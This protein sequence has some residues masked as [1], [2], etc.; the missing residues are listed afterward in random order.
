LRAQ[1]PASSPPDDLIRRV[2]ARETENEAARNDYTYRQTVTVEDLDPH[3]AR[4]G[5]YREV[6]DIVFSPAMVRS[7]QVVE[8]PRNTLK[9]L[10][11]TEEDFRDIREIQPLLIT[12]ESLFMY[13]S[14]FKG[15]EPMDGID[16][17]IL[18]V[19]P[20]QILQGQRL[21]DGMI[22]VDKTD[23]SIIRTEGQAVPQIRTMKT[24]N[25][26]PHFTTLRQ[27]FDGKFWFP[28]KTYADDTLYF[29][30]GPQRVRMI[31]R[32][33]EYKRFKAEST[34]EYK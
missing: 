34:I 7:E 16:C 15:E 27:K 8:K 6:R 3:G 28:V 29:R 12:R 1:E 21:F 11:M 22:W 32:Y 30:N 33:A 25:L 24:E 31:I 2:A 9:R 4:E 13:E 17:W 26:F 19:R 18:Q 23:Y 20:R 5:E 10:Q 14:K